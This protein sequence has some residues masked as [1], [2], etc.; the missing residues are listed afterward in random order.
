MKL[1]RFVLV[2][3]FQVKGVFAVL[4]WSV[5]IVVFNFWGGD[6]DW[7]SFRL[8][9]LGSGSSLTMTVME[10]LKDSQRKKKQGR[11]PNTKPAKSRLDSVV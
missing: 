7:Q 11:A 10:N 5:I 4:G 6:P 8:Q 9:D 1:V 3:L 2:F